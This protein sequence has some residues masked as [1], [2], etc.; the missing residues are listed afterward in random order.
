MKPNV[1]Q[2]VGIR[3]GMPWPSVLSLLTALVY[4]A[5]PIDLIPDFLLLLGWVDDAI[6]VP[7]LVAYAFFMWQRHRRQPVRVPATVERPV[8][9]VESR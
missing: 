6:A 4:G 7:L 8:M 2:S 3:P 1:S 9:D 5:S